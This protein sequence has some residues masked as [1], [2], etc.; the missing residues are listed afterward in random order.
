MYSAVSFHLKQRDVVRFKV[1][2][3]EDQENV[4][5]AF[6]ISQG[7][8]TSQGQASSSKIRPQKKTVSIST[9]VN[10]TK[11]KLQTA[12][13]NKKKTKTLTYELRKRRGMKPGRN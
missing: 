3:V 5:R 10:R 11:K 9:V 8:G 4:T 6:T 1:N 12:G 7:K 2:R 13:N